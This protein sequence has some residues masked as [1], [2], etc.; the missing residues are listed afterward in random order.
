MYK[1][2][3]LTF[4]FPFS[5]ESILN[6]QKIRFINIFQKYISKTLANYKFIPRLL[7]IYIITQ[8]RLLPC[9]KIAEP[10]NCAQQCIYQYGTDIFWIV[11][12]I[13]SLTPIWWAISWKD[14]LYILANVMFG[15]KLHYMIN[16]DDKNI[17]WFINKDDKTTLYIY[18]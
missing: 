10:C 14:A 3:V 13:L 6:S 16:K 8:F 1:K 7:A 12:K 5:M 2:N 17:I 15:I 18:K 4:H 9:A 11:N